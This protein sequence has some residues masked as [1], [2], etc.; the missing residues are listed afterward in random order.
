MGKERIFYFYVFVFTFTIIIV[1]QVMMMGK[2][3]LS[4]AS[5]TVSFLSKKLKLILS[6]QDFHF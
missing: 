5:C 3:K 2:V 1:M 4:K 6:F